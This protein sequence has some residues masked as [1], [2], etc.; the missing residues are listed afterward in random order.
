MSKA[1]SQVPYAVNEPVRTYEPG[2]TEVNSLIATYKKMWKEQVEIPM[3]INGK[4][5]TTENKVAISSPQDHQHN[6]GFYYKGDMTHVDEAINTALAAREKWNN[7]GWE[8]RAAIFLKAA[9]LIAGPYRDTLNAATMIGQSKNVHQAEIDAACEFID[10]LRYNVEFMT[11]IYSDQPVSDS[12]IWNRSEYRPLEGF[13]FAVTPFNFTAIAGNLPTCMAM[14][15][16]VVVWKPSDK[17]V[18]SAKIIMDI[19]TEAGLPAGV[20]N[21]IFTDGKET[22][23]KVLAHPDFAGLHFTG[24]TTVFQDMWKK[25]GN[26]IHQYKTYP[27]IVGETGGKDFIMV[28]PSANAEAVATGMV[29]GAFEY[30]GQKCSAASRAYIPKSLWPEVKNVMEAQLKT[31]KMGSPEDPSNFVNAVI[32]KNSF[33]KC[34][35]YIERAQQSSDAKV[36]FG[37]KCDD[38]KGWF[39]APTVIETT[40]PK[41][42]SVCEEIFGPILSVYVYE[43]IN[44]KETLKLVD[45]TSPYS[46]TGSIFSQDRYAIDEAYKALENAAGNFYINDK[47]TGAVVGQQPFGGARASGTNDKAGSK[48]NLLRWVSVRSIKETFVS[49]KDYKYPYLG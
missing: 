2:S 38:S 9:D 35:G 49:P 15:G 6:L 11:E 44:W 33:E 48:M 22:A 25:I 12:G 1:I 13:C 8:Q 14:M 28:H 17:Q 32:D 5:I 34:K 7:L 39:V 19:L 41:Y 47:P 40:N 24:S 27:R 42:E 30:Q 29:R 31:I 20:I 4:E 23:E 43:D 37:G 36:I 10:F 46:L 26:N 45:E 21:M 18:L 3:I 16:N